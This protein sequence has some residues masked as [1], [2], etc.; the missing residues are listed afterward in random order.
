[1]SY[2]EFQQ[3]ENLSFFFCFEFCVIECFYNMSNTKHQKKAAIEKKQ[4]LK[5]NRKC[6]SARST[7]RKKIEI[8]FQKNVFAQNCFIH[9]R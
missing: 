8:V 1:M 5:C 4:V 7:N 2:N 9:Q 3:F 6:F